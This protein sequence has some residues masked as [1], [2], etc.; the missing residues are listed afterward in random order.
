MILILFYGAWEG[1]AVVTPT[2]FAYG[3]VTGVATATSVASHN[4]TGIIFI[5]PSDKGKVSGTS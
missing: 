4:V 5:A 2:V 3:L 1:E